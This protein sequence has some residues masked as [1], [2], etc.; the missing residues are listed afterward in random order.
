LNLLSLPRST[1]HQS[2][3]D[4]KPLLLVY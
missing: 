1:W 3:D 2:T 4:W